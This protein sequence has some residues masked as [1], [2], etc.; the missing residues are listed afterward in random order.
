MM[1]GEESTVAVSLERVYARY[2][3]G[4][5]EAALR[6]VTLEVRLGEIVAVL[7]AN[8]AGKS[9]LLRVLAGSLAPSAGR[10]LLFGAPIR[11]VPRRELARTVAFVTQSE[12]V[13]FAF[14]VRD[15]VRMGRAPHQEGWMRPSAEDERVVEQALVELDLVGLADRPVDELSGGEKKRVTIARAFAQSSRVLLLDEPTAFLDIRHQVTLLEGLA[16]VVRSD[17]KA[18][19]LVTHDLQL[20]AAYAT[21]AVVMTKGRI[22]ADG[23]VDDVLTTARLAETFDWP[24]D[25]GRMGAEGPRVFAPRR[26]ATE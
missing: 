24:I 10:A 26:T 4:A 9:T 5:G 18:S 7:G 3:E 13:R 2:E 19:V 15:V 16:D 17:H 21:R 22:L 25:A 23:A 12:E 11:S 20:A 14:S 1:G 6:E 8:G